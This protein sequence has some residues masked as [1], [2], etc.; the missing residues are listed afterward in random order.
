MRSVVPRWRGAVVAAFFA[1]LAGLVAG[2]YE[3]LALS[4]LAF[5]FAAVG[6]SS[7]APEFGVKLT[8]ELDDDDA[9][10][11][12]QPVEVTLTVENTS[13]RRQ[14]DVRVYDSL[15][16]EAGLVEGSAS[17]AVSLE[18]DGAH[19]HSYSCLTPRGSH[20]F[21]E[22][23]VEQAD[24]MRT[25]VTSVELHPDGD[26]DMT[27][28]TVLES[29]P[30]M[31]QTVTSVGRVPTGD[32]GEGT[33]FHSTREYRRGDPV[34]RIDW[35]GFARTGEPS[36]VLHRM[37]RAVTVVFL[38]DDRSQAHLKPRGDGPDSLDL[39]LYAASRGVAAS[40]DDGNSTAV[41][42]L[43]GQWIPPG[44][45]GSFAE[46]AVR[47]VEEMDAGSTASLTDPRLV[48]SLTARLPRGSQVVFCTPTVD[49][50]VQELCRRLEASGH[51][52]MVVSPDLTSS[53][54]SSPADSGIPAGD[55]GGSRVSHG[56]RL[57]A[58]RRACWIDRLRSQGV[59]VA[60][61]SPTE[62]LS[63]EL[64]RL[65]ERWDR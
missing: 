32:G 13:G 25:T 59:A 61:W 16:E 47:V 22:A 31:D 51:Q 27:C 5:V 14:P 24:L 21:G 33:E 26:R 38:V 50:D 9:P 6:Y 10:S 60:D 11:P 17:F 29:H 12:G 7:S 43:G 20:E 34:S 15:P 35:R 55:S 42:S 19:S 28:E 65:R 2:S 8:R 64:A 56:V 1:F 4:V 57:E 3:V 36:T 30:F 46:R 58:V 37:Q 45:T 49:E 62:P 41:T 23:T 18:E 39:T 52:V 48:D 54:A 40:V 63:V 44:S 53:Y